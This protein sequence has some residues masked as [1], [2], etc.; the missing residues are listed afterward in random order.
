M[1]SFCSGSLQLGPLPA[2]AVGMVCPVS[3]VTGVTGW[4]CLHPAQTPVPGTQP[5]CTCSSSSGPLQHL[6]VRESEA[7]EWRFSEKIGQAQC[8]GSIRQARWL[9]IF[10]MWQTP[11]VS[12]CLLLCVFQTRFCCTFLHHFMHC[13]CPPSP[14]PPQ[15][16]FALFSVAKSRLVPLWND[17]RLLNSPS[18]SMS[19]YCC[20]ILLISQSCV[21]TVLTALPHLF[22]IFYNKVFNQMDLK[23]KTSA[24]FL[25]SLET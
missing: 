4:G 7:A 1:H 18:V 19:V 25:H 22:F 16:Q 6:C 8:L 21:C 24:S 14:T 20:L 12:F 9:L 17:A 23:A 13:C 11:S 3:P 5:V 15:P 10:H 2:P